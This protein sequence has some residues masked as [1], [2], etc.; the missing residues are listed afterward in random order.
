MVKK[1]NKLIKINKHKKIT[2][3]IPREIAIKNNNRQANA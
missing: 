3:W 1:N 2:E